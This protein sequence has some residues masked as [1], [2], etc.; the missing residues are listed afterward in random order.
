MLGV[1]VKLFGVSGKCFCV[2]ADVS[3]TFSAVIGNVSLN[4]SDVTTC[5]TLRLAEV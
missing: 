4:F 3:V 5:V 2:T 1:T